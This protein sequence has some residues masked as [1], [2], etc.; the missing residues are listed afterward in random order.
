MTDQIIEK[1]AGNVVDVNEESNTAQSH[2]DSE[3]LFQ[4]WYT[5]GYDIYDEAYVQWLMVH[6]PGDVKSEWL[7]KT[8]TTSESSEP[9]QPSEVVLNY[10]S[11]IGTLYR[12]RKT[13]KLYHIKPDGKCI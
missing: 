2:S 11:V 4:R 8:A 10:D 7:T 5:E 13:I 1:V 3:D 9:N 6:H 12:S